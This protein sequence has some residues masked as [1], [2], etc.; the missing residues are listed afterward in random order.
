MEATNFGKNVA[1]MNEKGCLEGVVD[2]EIKIL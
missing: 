1:T 2:S